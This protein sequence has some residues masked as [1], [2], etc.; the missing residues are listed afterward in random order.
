MRYIILGR[1][2]PQLEVGSRWDIPFASQQ[3]WPVRTWIH[4]S[5]DEGTTLMSGYVESM[6]RHLLPD[7]I[8]PNAAGNL[9]RRGHLCVTLSMPLGSITFCLPTSCLYSNTDLATGNTQRISS[10]AWACTFAY[11]EMQGTQETFVH[12]PVTIQHLASTRRLIC[13]KGLM[14]DRIYVKVTAEFIYNADTIAAVMEFRT[15][16]W[17]QRLEVL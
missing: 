16:E 10:V 4:Q 2:Q 5:N 7:S 13:P 3:K 14:Q 15:D 9:M 6:H 17:P 1:R 12:I 8:A 11:V